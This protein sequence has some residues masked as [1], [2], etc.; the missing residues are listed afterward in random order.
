MV[1]SKKIKRFKPQSNLDVVRRTPELEEGVRWLMNRSFQRVRFIDR[2]NR[3]QELLLQELDHAEIVVILKNEF[4]LSATNANESILYATAIHRAVFFE[5]LASNVRVHIAKKLEI[6]NQ[7]LRA[8]NPEGAIKI[9]D[10]IFHNGG[11]KK[12][13]REDIKNPKYNVIKELVSA[14]AK[15]GKD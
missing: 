6:A 5:S 4:D 8:G 12:K 15:A 11:I 10:Y 7:L 13:M 14:M 3:A 2:I 9:L 1:N